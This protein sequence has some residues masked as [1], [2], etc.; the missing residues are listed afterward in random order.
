M[1]N[2]NVIE[3]MN[4][5]AVLVMT[6]KFNRDKLGGIE[7]TI[8]EFIKTLNEQW[9]AKDQMAIDII[10]HFNLDENLFNDMCKKVYNE[11][12]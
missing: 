12:K 6:K 1:D 7:T 8:P 10:N 11:M 9:Y 4:F 5:M 3:L 2:I